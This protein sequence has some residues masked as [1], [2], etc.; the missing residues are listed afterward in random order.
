LLTLKSRAATAA[1]IFVDRQSLTSQK[2][3][4]FC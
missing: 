4:L 1:L 3:R 2:G